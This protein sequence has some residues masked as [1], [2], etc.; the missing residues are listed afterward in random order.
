M[1]QLPQ[2]HYHIQR[3]K[4]GIQ[5]QDAQVNMS[6]PEADLRISQPEADLDINYRPSKLTIDQTE[7]LR[8]MGII[9]TEESVRKSANEGLQE[10]FEGISR[11]A[12]EGT[13]MQRIEN[14]GDVIPH[15]AKENRPFARQDFTIGWIPSSQFAVKIDYDPGDVDINVQKNEPIIDAQANKPHFNYHEGDVNIYLQQAP[16]LEIDVDIDTWRHHHYDIKI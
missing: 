16:H 11:R 8:D 4:I 3:G 10:A 15:I 5:T 13:Q 14:G 1:L 9:S 7:A 6:Q 2:V 12:R